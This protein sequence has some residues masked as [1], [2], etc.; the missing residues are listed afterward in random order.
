MG[1]YD[2]EIIRRF[3]QVNLCLG[4][5][6]P[7]A[8]LPP[9]VGTSGGSLGGAGSLASNLLAALSLYCFVG[10]DRVGGFGTDPQMS[11]IP[12]IASASASTSKAR[13][14][15]VLFT[16]ACLHSLC[17][18]RIGCIRTVSPS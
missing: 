7:I 2:I 1:R 8:E 5:F 6:T 16:L 13:V 15:T 14:V 3:L 12:P 11:A 10:S 18:V 4:R 9:S 17:P